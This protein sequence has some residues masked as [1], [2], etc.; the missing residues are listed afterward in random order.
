[1]ITGSVKQGTTLYMGIVV[2]KNGGTSWTPVRVC[3]LA[4]SES[5]VAAFAP[6]NANVLYV[7]GHDSSW[8]GII[9]RSANGG[10][11]WTDVTGEVNSEPY[12]LAVDLQDANIVY[13][14]TW[15]GLWRSANG[16]AA[17]AKCTFPTYAYNFRAV[18]M[19]PSN[20]QEVFAGHDKGVFH[21]QDRG[22]TW[23]DLGAGLDIPSVQKLFFNPATR[24]LYAATEGGGLW[25]R[26]L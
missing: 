22:L 24:T 16:G 2:S 6:G 23:T 9:Y 15:G 1:M 12:A 19:N 20:P 11:S 5:S 14:G 3:A 21:S 7:S 4:G 13:A 25:K 10:A 17:W 18:A 26:T 8:D